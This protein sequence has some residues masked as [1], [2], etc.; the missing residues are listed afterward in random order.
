M[1][2]Q[3]YINKHSAK[4]DKVKWRGHEIL[5]IEAFS[6]GVFAFVISLLIV[7]LEVP[8]SSKELL[9]TMVG[10]FP[11]AICFGF[12]LGMWHN[13]YKFFRRF[14]LHDG[15]TILINAAFIFMAL[16]YV[17]PLKFILNNT[18]QGHIYKL[19]D[20]DKG[21]L[22]M[23]YNG[24]IGVIYMLFTWMYH[25]AY[26]KR[27][28]LGLS[29][30]EAFETIFFTLYYAVPALVAFVATFIVFIYRNSDMNHI[31]QCFTA[32]ASLGI[33]MPLLGYIRDKQFKKRF[34]NEPIGEPRLGEE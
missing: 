32:Y 24:G 21:I 13:Q 28:D 19:Y 2:R 18:F 23:F 1:I 9:G 4:K 11:F 10:F 29:K 3:L 15:R 25:H 7:S 22:F 27:T 30:E 8:K 17:F 20:E 31:S 5:R 34:G 26:R 14:G 33:F 12:V 6:D 16:L